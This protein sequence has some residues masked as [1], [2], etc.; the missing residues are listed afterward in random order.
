[1]K[2]KELNDVLRSRARQLGLCDEWYNGWGKKENRQQL[3]EK[4]LRGIDFCIKHD[5]P[6][7]AFIKSEFPN[8]LLL[9]NGIFVDEDVDATNLRKAVALGQSK[10]EIRYDGLAVGAVYVRHQSEI[11]ITATDGAKVFVETYENCKLKASADEY[12][13]IFVYQYGG[14]VSHDG[15]VVVRNKI[16]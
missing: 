3:I 15:N 7:L 9:G 12:S 5:Y 8:D 1:M 4:Y 6:T 11:T 13:R 16:S 14:E 10:G 2:E